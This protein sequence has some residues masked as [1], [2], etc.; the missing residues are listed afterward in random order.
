MSNNNSMWFAVDEEGSEWAY[1]K[2]PERRRTEW[3]SSIYAMLEFPKGSIQAITGRVL[4]W[5]DEPIEWKPGEVAIIPE[6]Y[7]V[8]ECTD[9]HKFTMIK[10]NGDI[11][12]G[13]CQN[14]QHP[15]FNE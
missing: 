8:Y 2:K 10:N 9:C 3:Y 4:T 14:C 13:M 6:G 7:K 11:I 1:H 5:A 12:P 15:L